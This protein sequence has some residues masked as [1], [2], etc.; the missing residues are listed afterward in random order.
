MESVSFQEQGFSDFETG[1]ELHDAMRVSF[2]DMVFP[3]QKERF[4]EI[5][6]FVNQF[7]DALPLI[8]G[9]MSRKPADVDAIDHIFSFV[10]LQTQRMDLKSK[11][12][13]LEDEI[14]FYE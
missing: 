4:G 11:L 7:G 1:V 2:E 9:A 12:R 3:K 5:V 6:R 13:Q 10:N 8:R 14:S